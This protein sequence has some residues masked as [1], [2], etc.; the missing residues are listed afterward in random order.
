MEPI[1]EQDLRETKEKFKVFI[2]DSGIL[3]LLFLANSKRGLSNL[4]TL[5]AKLMIDEVLEIYRQ[6]P[7]KQCK[8]LVDLSVLDNLLNLSSESRKIYAAAAA[9]PQTGKIAAVGRRLFY[10]IAINFIS[11]MSGRDL[12]WFED[13]E[14]A[15][16][17]LKK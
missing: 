11:R 15:L 17:W 5:M 16:E 4:Q 1:S 8:V 10:K 13:R 14:K 9:H 12:R 3:N 2:D 7:G 6:N